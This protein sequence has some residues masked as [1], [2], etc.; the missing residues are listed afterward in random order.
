MFLILVYNLST[1]DR[2]LHTAEKLCSDKR[3]VVGLGRDLSVCDRPLLILVKDHDIRIFALCEISL[4]K[5]IQLRRIHAHLLHKLHGGQVAFLHKFCHRKAK[6]RL[7]TDDSARSFPYRKNCPFPPRC[8]E[9][10][11]W[12]SCRWNRPCTSLDN[13]PRGPSQF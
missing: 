7:K 6:R 11:R 2:I 5:V 1:A 8:A 4:I 12:R 3:R 13:R 10:G 9:R